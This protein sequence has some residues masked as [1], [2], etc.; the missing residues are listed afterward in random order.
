MVKV[1]RSYSYHFIRSTTAMIV[2][3]D[4]LTKQVKQCSQCQNFKSIDFFG[5]YSYSSDGLRA[6]CKQ[7]DQ[8]MGRKY[9]QSLP[10]SQRENKNKQRSAR[11][12]KDNQI[13]HRNLGN[14][15]IYYIAHPAQPHLVK[16][17]Y[18]S[19]FHSRLAAFLTSS[20]KLLLVAL[21]QVHDKQVENELHWRFD[22]LR[23]EGEWFIAKSPLLQHLDS[24]DSSIAQ[25]CVSLLPSDYQRRI[26]VPSK[27]QF[28]DMVPFFR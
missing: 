19:S 14:H 23:Y 5:N 16:I 6:Y 7:C 22:P 10:P 25:Q 4:A 20:P 1:A 26:I 21:S 15:L 9:R 12:I 27:Y 17:G 11:K 2:S 24:L 13:I 18:S 3:Q 28:V 8:I